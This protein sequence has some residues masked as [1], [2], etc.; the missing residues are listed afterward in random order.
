M[1]TLTRQDPWGVGPR[2]QD[3][4]NRLFGSA[5]ENDSSSATAG[6]VTGG[7]TLG[8]GGGVGIG[9]ATGAAA[10]KAVGSGSA[11][12]GSEMELDT[13]SGSAEPSSS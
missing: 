13:G 6:W 9:S 10:W 5:R 3:E 11:C 4:I 2:L 1:N 7:I 8:A 12:T